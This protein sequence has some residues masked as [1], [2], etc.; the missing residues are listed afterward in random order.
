MSAAMSGREFRSLIMSCYF[1]VVIL[2][3]GRKCLLCFLY[4]V[5]KPDPV[6]QINLVICWSG[7]RSTRF[8]FKPFIL[9][10]NEV[11]LSFVFV[12]F[13]HHSLG[14]SIGL[15]TQH[16]T[17]ILVQVNPGLGLIFIGLRHLGGYKKLVEDYCC[18]WPRLKLL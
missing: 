11:I 16:T 14:W 3:L 4:L 13:K 10:Q 12:L 9:N 2:F 5:I 18:V 15:S 8:H 7:A 17:R 1:F 6:K